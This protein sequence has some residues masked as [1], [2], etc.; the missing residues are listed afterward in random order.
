MSHLKFHLKNLGEDSSG[1]KSHAGNGDSSVNKPDY[2]M[3]PYRLPNGTKMYLPT[4]PQDINEYEEGKLG[5]NELLQRSG[6]LPPTDKE[7]DNQVVEIEGTLFVEKKIGFVAKNITMFEWFKK[8]VGY[9]GYLAMFVNDC[10][11]DF[12][13]QRGRSLK[14]ITEGD[15]VEN[16]SRI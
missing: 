4:R 6:V 7:L 5:V 14:V 1:K 15:D 11:E 2:V 10:I 8:N 13:R 9:T 3:Y 12:F 16:P